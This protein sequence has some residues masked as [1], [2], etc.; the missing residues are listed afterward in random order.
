[1]KCEVYNYRGCRS[2]FPNNVARQCGVLVEVKR[3]VQG[4]FL[5]G[6]ATCRPR[7]SPPGSRRGEP[8]EVRGSKTCCGSSGVRFRHSGVHSGV[9][10]GVHPG[11]HSWVHSGCRQC[12]FRGA[13]RSAFRSGCRSAFLGAF[14]VHIMDSYHAFVSGTLISVYVCMCMSG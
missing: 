4:Y 8:P 9:H 10:P 5:G 3:R 1:M 12:A 13:S 2:L 6:P 11:V 7:G 14:R